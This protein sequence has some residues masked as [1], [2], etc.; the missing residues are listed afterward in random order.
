[1]SLQ[2]TS[3]PFSAA[4]L[5]GGALR[6]LLMFA[7]GASIAGCGGSSN[8][9]RLQGTVTLGGQPLP[10]DLV[11]AA[12]IFAPVKRGAQKGVASPIVDGRYDAKDVPKGEVRV[13]FSL[14]QPTG[15]MLQEGGGTPY[16]EMR[17]LAPPG[18]S[19]KVITVDGNNSSLDFDL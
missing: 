6:L 12:I 7:V 4:R 10:D 16:A 13:S 11:S 14:P 1:M 17:D 3:K 2:T 18:A 19:G 15:K 9:A 5:R 8:S